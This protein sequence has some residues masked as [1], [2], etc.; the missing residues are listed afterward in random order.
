MANSFVLLEGSND[1]GWV[2]VS[3]LA[4]VSIVV[5]GLSVG[6]VRTSEVIFG[7]AG[8]QVL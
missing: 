8:M 3:L 6:L 2:I 4:A 7:S 1:A 5:T